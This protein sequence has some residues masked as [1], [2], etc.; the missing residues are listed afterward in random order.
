MT[1]R[2]DPQLHKQSKQSRA[3]ALLEKPMC[4]SQLLDSI[5]V[6][7]GTERQRLR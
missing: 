1:G 4:E 7:L 3:V 5:A 2:A 6:A